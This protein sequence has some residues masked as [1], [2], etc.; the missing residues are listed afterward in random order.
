MPKTDASAIAK[1]RRP[2][3]NFSDVRCPRNENRIPFFTRIVS[4]RRP[5]SGSTRIS[6]TSSTPRTAFRTSVLRVVAS[7]DTTSP[8]HRTERDGRS[9][10]GAEIGRRELTRRSGLQARRERDLRVQEARDGTA[11]LRG[12]RGLL[13]RLLRGSRDARVRVEVHLRHREPRLCLL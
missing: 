13:E 1:P 11:R 4:P 9:A 12:V 3:L 2:S 7:T 6:S 8:S 10:L 5:F